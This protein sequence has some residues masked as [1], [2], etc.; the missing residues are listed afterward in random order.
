MTSPLAKGL[1]HR[2]IMHS[3]GGP[4][5]ATKGA[6]ENWGQQF[7]ARL[8]VTTLD[9]ARALPSEAL[10]KAVAALTSNLRRKTDGYAAIARPTSGV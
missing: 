3:G 10:V 4:P 5:A 7:F 1:F 2:A 8:G 9:Q 6:S